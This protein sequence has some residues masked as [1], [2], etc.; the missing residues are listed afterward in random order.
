MDSGPIDGSPPSG[1]DEIPMVDGEPV[2]GPLDPAGQSSRRNLAMLFVLIGAFVAIMGVTAFTV[3]AEPTSQADKLTVESAARDHQRHSPYLNG[4]DNSGQLYVPAS[5]ADGSVGSST[6]S[7]TVGNGLP[8]GYGVGPHGN[9]GATPQA[10]GSGSPSHKSSASN[11]NGGG[12]TTT[13]TAASG[14]AFTSVTPATGTTVA[15]TGAT[16]TT[17][18]SGAAGVA[19]VFT[20][21]TTDATSVDL[22]I[23]TPTPIATGLA[24]TGAGATYTVTFAC[25]GPHTITLTAHGSG[26]TTATSAITLTGA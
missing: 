7:T 3:F 6:G 5:A 2:V 4:D 1:D 26:T 17:D 21:D 8:V 19:V 25:P 16:T 15:C 12:K 10:K 22:A 24:P 9:V 20:W 23:D 13:T 14:V 11:A 18:G